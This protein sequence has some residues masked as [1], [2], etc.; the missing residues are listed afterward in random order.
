M[1][2]NKTLQPRSRPPT[3]EDAGLED[4]PPMASGGVLPDAR[5][6]AAS[7]LELPQAQLA[8]LEAR[9]MDRLGAQIGDQL[10]RMQAQMQSQ[11]Q[12][13]MQSQ[14]QSQ[15]QSQLQSQMQS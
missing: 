3:P 1:P 6:I 12:S 10:T 14:L 9:L 4:A 8:Q 13:Q 11:L 5:A 7:V 15:M 2:L